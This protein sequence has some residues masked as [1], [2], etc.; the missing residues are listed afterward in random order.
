[1]RRFSLVIGSMALVALGSLVGIVAAQSQ[2]EPNLLV[3]SIY[4]PAPGRSFN[5]AT[6]EMSEIVRVH[7]ATGAYKSVR[8][9]SHNWGPEM[10]FYLVTEPNDWASIP[11]GFQA[12]LEADPDLLDRPDGWE[13]HS[14]NIL[15]E[16]VVE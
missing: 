4:D 3:I 16:I 13:A 10:A 8:L 7:R 2:E 9:F 14:D 6:E 11:E 15:A 12:E 1:M 5:D